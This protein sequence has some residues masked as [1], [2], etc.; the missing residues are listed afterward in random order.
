[1][2]TQPCFI[3]KNTPELREKLQKLGQRANTLD[4]FKEEWLAAN[5]GMYISVQDGFQHLHPN[6]I[7]CGTN[8]ELFLAIAAL[9]DD[10]D[11]DQWFI[12]DVDVYLNMD[13]GSWFK[14]TDRSGG[15]HIGTQI[16]PMYCHKATVQELIEH[17]SKKEEE[18]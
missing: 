3:R 11:R 8:E 1:M 18:P 5:Y 9:R 13:K 10:T 4:D 12:L 16:E 14:A 2:F 17:F 7:D 6:D 15:L